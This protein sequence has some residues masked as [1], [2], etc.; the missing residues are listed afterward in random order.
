[1]DHSGLAT[2]PPAGLMEVFD[3]N[4]SVSELVT[5]RS[6]AMDGVPL[7]PAMWLPSSTQSMCAMQGKHDRKEPRA[8]KRE[9]ESPF[10]PEMPYTRCLK[11]SRIGSRI[12]AGELTPV[13]KEA[14]SSTRS[15][16]LIQ[17][18]ARHIQHERSTSIFGETALLPPIC[19]PPTEVLGRDS[20]NG[21]QAI[22]F[23]A[24]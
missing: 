22:C 18:S 9:I 13:A 2:G 17:I 19:L 7:Q 14:S 24:R 23:N 5:T 21:S 10:I 6:F 3:S 16:G 20:T 12:L 4:L 11:A 1:M 8:C 15:H